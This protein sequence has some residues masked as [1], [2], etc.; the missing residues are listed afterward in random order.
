MISIIIPAYNAS[1]YIAECLRSIVA[2]S[3]SDKEVI[4]VDD[5]STDTTAAIVRKQFPEV[6][7]ISRENGG[8]SAARNT[9]LDNASGEWVTFV[10]ADD[11]LLPDALTTLLG[12]AESTGADVVNGN[13]IE[14]L[15]PPTYLPGCPERRASLSSGTEAMELTFY[16]K[17]DGSAW[18]KLYRNSLFKSGIRFTEG[19]YYE[20]LDIIYRLYAAARKVAH[21]PE[22]VY[23]YRLSPEGISRTLSPKRFDLLTVA[24][25]LESYI[26]EHFPEI[27]RSA[28]NRRLAANLHVL[29]L[30][31]GKGEEYEAIRSQCTAQ[32]RRLR[33]EAIFDAKSRLKIRVGALVSYLLYPTRNRRQ[34][35]TT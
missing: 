13:H 33:K 26:T 11:M 25:K 27:A 5:G 19:L 3:I 31:R 20:D 1:A 24:E 17:I 8:L 21:I 2:Q 7:L 22:N 9:G 15:T 32:V 18:G 29:A 6:K 35:E 14:G 28:R 10:D 23:F 4:V 34:A 30:L 12:Y 16:R